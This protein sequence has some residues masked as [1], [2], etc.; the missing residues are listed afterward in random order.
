[1]NLL[2]NSAKYTSEGGHIGLTDG[3]A[4]LRLRDDGVGIA[5][6]L[7]PKVFEVFT[8]A[9]R[10]LDRSQGGLGLGLTLAKKP[11]E[12]HGGS[13]GA[14]SGGL[15]QGSEFVVRLPRLAGPTG[16]DQVGGLAEPEGVQPAPAARR[17]LVVDGNVDAADSLALLLRL[18]GNDVRTAYDGPAALGLIP[19]YRPD[20]VFLDTGLPGMGGY[21]VS[22][23][24]AGLPN[25]VP[26]ALTGYGSAGDRGRSDE[27]GFYAHLARP[28]NP[29]D[30]EKL[31][32]A[33]SGARK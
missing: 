19:E 20:V 7:P 6:D 5:P 24:L 29:A 10:M 27:L 13:V 12:M 21:E 16:P 17:I 15:G 33:L 11:A 9:E 28:V 31:R 25:V 8:Q 18:T 4:V 1:M 26:V 30:V 3:E 23:R 2:N 32:G 14:F 22:R